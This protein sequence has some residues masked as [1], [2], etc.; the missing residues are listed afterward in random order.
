VR[1]GITF[2]AISAQ[3]QDL[4]TAEG[5]RVYE[6]SHVYGRSLEAPER[7]APIGADVKHVHE[8]FLPSSRNA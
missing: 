5:E 3:Q 7:Y 6:L 2:P 4:V 1:S 8:V